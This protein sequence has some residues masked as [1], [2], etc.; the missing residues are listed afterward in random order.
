MLTF[1]T[2]TAL[3]S[4]VARCGLQ[5]ALLRG[6]TCPYSTFAASP[7]GIR[8][9][10][11]EQQQQVPHAG[12]RKP[13]ASTTRGA[14][15]PRRSASTTSTQ[16]DAAAAAAAAASQT[17]AHLEVAP[18]DWNSFFR[19][20]KTRRRW[21]LAFSLTTGAAGGTAGALFLSS[22]VADPVVNTI[23]L[24]PFVTLGLMTF[25]FAALG[26]LIGPSLGSAIFYALN[27]KHR[28]Q[29]TLVGSLLLPP[30]ERRADRTRVQKETQFF[31]R[32]KKNRVDPS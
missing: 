10:I 5:P 19:L 20:R 4:G 18:L 24:D 11:Q 21:Q 25:G 7:F 3:R 14:S 17:A 13:L 2:A 26:W 12:V 15:V 23:P 31:A 30:A 29:M 16:Q 6:S 22:G 28:A 8:P 32:I 27:R 1:T 9:K